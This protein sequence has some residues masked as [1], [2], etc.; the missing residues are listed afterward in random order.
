M[1]LAYNDRELSYVHDAAALAGLKPAAYAARQ[2]LAV[3]KGE[4]VPLPADEKERLKAFS[5]ARVAVDRIGT[6]VH[7]IARVLNSGGEQTPEQIVAVLERAE[8][9]LARLDDATIAL[10]ERRG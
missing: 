4:L 5:E 3:A 10:M 6:N 9:A 8:R 2:A 7:Q 1:N